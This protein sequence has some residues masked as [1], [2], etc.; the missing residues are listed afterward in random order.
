MQARAKHKHY[1]RD[2]HRR[3]KKGARDRHMTLYRQHTDIAKIIQMADKGK[4]GI[5]DT[6]AQG[7]S[8]S[9]NLTVFFP[10]LM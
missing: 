8:Q 2:I 9:N 5:L 1:S 4:T 6:P 10:P 3:L 7:E